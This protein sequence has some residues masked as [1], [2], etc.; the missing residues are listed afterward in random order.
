MKKEAKEMVVGVRLGLFVVGCIATFMLA[1]WCIGLVC[2]SLQQ[3]ER[4]NPGMLAYIP[5][6][7]FYFSPLAMLG[8][9]KV[10]QYDLEWLL[11][12][13]SREKERQ[14]LALARRYRPL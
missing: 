7:V 4:Y 11:H 5:R 3:G 14:A 10:V 2:Y 6:E 13:S 12:Y 1:F 9:F 8:L